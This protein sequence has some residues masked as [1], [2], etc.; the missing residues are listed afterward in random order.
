MVIRVTKLSSM[1]AWL[2]YGQAKCKGTFG[3]RRLLLLL[4]FVVLV[5]LCSTF[6]ANLL[7]KNKKPQQ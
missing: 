1:F 3:W 7:S 2:K 4:F 5:C 6:K